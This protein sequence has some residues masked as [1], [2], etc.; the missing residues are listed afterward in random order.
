MNLSNIK[1]Y[2]GAWLLTYGIGL[3]IGEFTPRWFGWSLHL[4]VSVALSLS[5]T[6]ITP[7]LLKS[8]HPLF[9]ILAAFTVFTVTGFFLIMFPAL[10]PLHQHLSLP[11]TR[12]IQIIYALERTLSL[13]IGSYVFCC[14]I[15][16]TKRLKIHP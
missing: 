15:K 11:V 13:V 7:G 3:E 14:G 8:A 10:N 1:L 5:L 9:R 2:F 6:F 12:Q 4:S 16:K